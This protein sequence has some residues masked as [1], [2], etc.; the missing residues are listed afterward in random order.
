MRII[1]A[2]TL[3]ADGFTTSRL[4]AAKIGGTYLTL[5]ALR[6]TKKKIKNSERGQNS[7]LQSSSHQLVSSRT[8]LVVSRRCRLSDL[9]SF[10]IC[11]KACSMRDTSFFF[12][13]RSPLG[14]EGLTW[15]A[16]LFLQGSEASQVSPPRPRG[17][18]PEK[19]KC[20]PHSIIHPT[21]VETQQVGES[22]P[23]GKDYQS[24]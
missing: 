12:F 3:A 2:G 11:R 8:K 24:D 6:P 17:P 5:A 14:R 21:A 7:V 9:L 1:F 18:S 20:I 23:P 16:K 13:G 22:A 19:E 10:H 15:L 4:N